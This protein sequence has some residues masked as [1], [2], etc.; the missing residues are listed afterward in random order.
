M[1]VKFLLIVLCFKLANLQLIVPNEKDDLKQCVHSLIANISSGYDTVLFY[2]DNSYD[3][4]FYNLIKI[5]FI[6]INAKG[7]IYNLENYS[8]GR[9]IVILSI[10]KSNDVTYFFRQMMR[11][12]L[13]TF[14]SARIRRFVIILPL[15]QHYWLA[16]DL[17]SNLWSIHVV[18]VVF[19]Y[20]DQNTIRLFTSD[21]QHPKNE[22]GRKAKFI[23]EYTFNS[24]KKIKFPKLWRSYENCTLI[25]WYDHPMELSKHTNEMYFKGI[26]LLE[27][28]V[29]RLHLTL[30]KEKRNNNFTY[31]GF[32]IFV[33][34]ISHCNHRFYDCS[35]PFL[36][37][38][39][40]WIVP[41]PK[42]IH[43]LE[44]FRITFKDIVWILIISSFLFTS[45]TWWFISKRN[46][47]NSFVSSSLDIY[48]AT[49]FGFINRIPPFLSPRLIFITYVFYAVHI[50]TAFTSQLIRLLTVP[51]YG[52]SITSLEELSRSPFPIFTHE[53]T[54]VLFEH[55]EGRSNYY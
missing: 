41:A 46:D 37:N 42:I 25:Y 8:I 43:A 55:E 23:Y 13:W 36:S 3:H 17:L 11:V 40:V 19:V 10:S 16:R 27:T 9:D 7:T 12:G 30:V 29:Q 2:S 18:E 33:N 49:L 52:H 4:T 32:R 47:N 14:R 20:H 26:F 1:M 44:V 31:Y 54:S 38:E 48:S 6:N 5:P 24:I 28:A 15:Q 53:G 39:L 21:P 51:Q 50:Q 35:I 45:L 22:C 34:H